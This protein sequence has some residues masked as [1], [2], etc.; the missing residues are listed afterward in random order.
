MASPARP[1]EFEDSPS[2]LVDFVKEEKIQRNQEVKWDRIDDCIEKKLMMD[3]DIEDCFDGDG[4]HVCIWPNGGSTPY[5]CKT[6]VIKA[7]SIATTY[8][9]DRDFIW[10]FIRY[11][12]RKCPNVEEIKIVGNVVSMNGFYIVT[13]SG[14][15]YSRF[16]AF[17]S[18]IKVLKKS[19]LV[20]K[21]FTKGS[22]RMRSR[23]LRTMY[24]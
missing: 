18:G 12:V 3:K 16:A 22:R 11:Y 20:V 14:G 15:F 7:D 5:C 19:P 17:I 24:R 13:S 10:D 8:G 1:R 4:E 9:S 21:C 23:V 2:W 6:L